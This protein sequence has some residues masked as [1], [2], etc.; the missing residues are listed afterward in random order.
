M[1]KLIMTVT[2]LALAAATAG[3]TYA[4]TTVVDDGADTPG[5]SADI[6][7]V[8]VNHKLDRLVVRSTYRD[9]RK[10]TDGEVSSTAIFI[11]SKK[12][13]KGPELALVSGLQDGTDYQLVRV[14]D[15]KLTGKEVACGYSFKIR[16]AKNLTRLKLDRECFG[17][18]A[19]VRISQ[20]TAEESRRTGRTVDWAPAKRAYSPWVRFN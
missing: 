16:W 3:P 12:K 13:R 10:V 20:Q 1:R 9:L 2:A 19:S 15:W 7:K 14:K 18:R 6:R 8:K 5:M 11:D 4:A 17:K